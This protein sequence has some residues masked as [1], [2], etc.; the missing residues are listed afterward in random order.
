MTYDEASALND[1][2][3]WSPKNYKVKR[4]GIWMLED[5]LFAVPDCR[6]SEVYVKW[7]AKYYCFRGLLT[8]RKKSS[9]KC[10]GLGC[11]G[12]S[13]SDFNYYQNMCMAI[14]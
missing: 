12:M 5:N 4:T 1:L 3:Y 13:L 9:I 6:R 11:L 8:E 14:H 10:V 2:I 7:N